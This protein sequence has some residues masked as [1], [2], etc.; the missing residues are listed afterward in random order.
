MIQIEKSGEV[1]KRTL[2][3]ISRVLIIFILH[4]SSTLILFFYFCIAFLCNCQFF[5]FK[6]SARILI[7]ST[8]FARRRSFAEYWKYFVARFNDVHAFGSNS[9]GSE[10]ISKKIWELRVHC[11]PKGCRRTP[12]RVVHIAHPRV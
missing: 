6:Y 7:I 5:A 1:C 10:R 2:Y 9:T 12:T 11:K 4:P 3:V 8:V